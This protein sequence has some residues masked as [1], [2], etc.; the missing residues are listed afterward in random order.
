MEISRLDYA[1]LSFVLKAYDVGQSIYVH[2]FGAFFGKKKIKFCL[3]NKSNQ[4][5]LILFD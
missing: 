4:I 5:R 1:P 2:V 3:L